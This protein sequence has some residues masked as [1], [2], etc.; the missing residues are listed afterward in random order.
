MAQNVVE[1]VL[2][3]C[4]SALRARIPIIYIKT[5]SD[6]LIQQIVDSDRLVLRIRKF[7]AMGKRPEREY[8]TD[9]NYVR[10]KPANHLTEDI[11]LK[12]S[13]LLWDYPRICTYKVP[14]EWKNQ[15][16][17]EAYIMAHEDPCSRQYEI[18]QNSV[19]ILYSSQVQLSP[20][21]Q[22]Y[23]EI[24]EVDYPGAE[25]IRNLILNMAKLFGDDYLEIDEMYQSRLCSE[26]SGLTTDEI[27][28]TMRRILS[29]PTQTP[30]ASPLLDEAAVMDIIRRRKEQKMETSVLE[31]CK[32]PGSSIG[33]MDKLR[34]WLSAQKSALE[35]A[36]ILR[37]RKGI[38]PPKGVLLCGIP[39]CGKSEAAKLT[40]Q[41]FGLP[42]LKMDMG[43]L[44]DKYQGESER[45]MTEALRMAEAMSPCVLWIDELEKGFGGAGTDNDSSSFKRMFAT[46]LGWMQDNTRP[47]FIFATANNIGGLPKEFFRSG[48]F[49]ALFA[50]YLPLMQECVQIFKACMNRYKL[51]SGESLFE[52]G[53]DDDDLLEYVIDTCLVSPKRPRIVV[54]ADIQK[55]VNITVR[56]LGGQERISR[57]QWRTALIRTCSDPD[58]GVYGD[59]EENVDSIAVSYCRMLR[60]GLQSTSDRVLFSTED[61]QPRNAKDKK[62]IL[63]KSDSDSFTNAYD[64]AVY[65]MLLERIN[66]MAP[67]VEEME[68][69]QV[70]MR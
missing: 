32:Q 12:K 45:N 19:V 38:L 4:E 20:M 47:V 59:G 25:E 23:T 1:K 63:V 16:G 58:V 9:E 48:R 42:L 24:I 26:F 13:W 54:G 3:R 66:E 7:G 14:K 69:R 41:E 49:D 67:E 31:L 33:G 35:N 15:E 28:V 50:V 5:D 53:C 56:G 46:M 62:N 37:R 61:Y 70:L 43:R 55:I 60:K 68:R 57:K 21:M 44:M 2:R 51:E 11:G 10:E 40:A 65:D 64:R 34:N 39:G 8:R 18:L 22:A 52:P 17:Y 36:E 30:S 27:D 6:R 29:V